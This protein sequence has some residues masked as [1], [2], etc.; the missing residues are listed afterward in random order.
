MFLGFL[1][2]STIS[3]IQIYKQEVRGHSGYYVCK[4]MLQFNHL[5]VICLHGQIK[6]GSKQGCTTSISSWF[7]LQFEVQRSNAGVQAGRVSFS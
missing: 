7:V 2:L 5:Y 1:G 3:S 6:R 4:T